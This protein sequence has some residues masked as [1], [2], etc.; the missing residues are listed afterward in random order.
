MSRSQINLQDAFLNHV[1]KEKIPVVLNLSGGG[2]VAGLVKGFDNFVILVKHEG[3][4]LVYKHAINSIVPER[5]VE[6]ASSAS[7]VKA[8]DQPEQQ[9]DI[10][11]E[12]KSVEAT[13]RDAAD[14]G[15]ETTAKP[16]A[17]DEEPW[18]E[19]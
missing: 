4:H 8:P 11:P 1:R 7:G 3:Q 18:V 19:G 17:E 13:T 14:L 16:P 2:S 15:A 9:E 12:K 10:K 6:L 5:P